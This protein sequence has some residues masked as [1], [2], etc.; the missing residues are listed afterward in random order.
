MG[1]GQPTKLA[2]NVK[3]RLWHVFIAKLDKGTTENEV[4]NHLQDKGIVVSRV[5]L[6]KPNTEW[7]K[8]CAAFRA[9]VGDSRREAV[10][11]ADPWPP[12]I[13]IRDWYFKTKSAVVEYSSD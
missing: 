1:T 5:S 11:N 3:D 2:S 12:D 9:S 8:R 4:I 10:F 6:L 13:E 7:Q